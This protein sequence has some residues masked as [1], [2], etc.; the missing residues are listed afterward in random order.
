MEKAAE[1]LEKAA[2][3]L[4][5]YKKNKTLVSPEDL[6]GKY[7]APFQKLKA[8][9]KDELSEYLKAY[10]LEQLIVKKDGSGHFEELM[11]TV[12]R[13][14]SESGIG[15]QV[16]RAA[17][18]DFDLEQVKRLAE[19]LRSRIYDEAWVPYFQK[20]TCVY[21]TG[22]CFAEDNPQSPRIYNSLVD[23]FWSEAA[24]EWIADEAAK[25]PAVLI[26]VQSNGKE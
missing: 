26:Y 9:L 5:K 16:G 20:Y 22:E 19:D 14:F 1:I 11:E 4:E 15:K 13:I 24:G 7:K 25:A 18:R 17:F 12:N 2:V 3:S 8:Q 23:K 6:V 10:S 21:A